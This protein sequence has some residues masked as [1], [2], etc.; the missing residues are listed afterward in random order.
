MTFAGTSNATYSVW[1]STNLISWERLG[2]AQPLTG[3]GYQFSDL[4]A[5]NRPHRFYRAVAP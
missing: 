1:A 3:S 5:T 2:T 4:G